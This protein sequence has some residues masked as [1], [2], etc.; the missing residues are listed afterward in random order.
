MS[1]SLPDRL[2][3]ELSH[4][5]AVHTGLSFP[6]KKW[7]ALTKGLGA[8]S[9]EAGFNDPQACARKILESE[10]SSS[11]LESLVEQLTIGE[12][13]FL[14][15]KQVF[16]ALQDHV[17]RGLV[18]NPRRPDKSMRFWSAGCATGE[19]PFSIAILMDRQ[20]HLDKGRDIRIAGTDVNQR[21][22]NHAK[23]GIYTAWSLRGVPVSIIDKYF[24][25]HPPNRFELIPRIRGKV[26][27]SRLNFAVPDYPK[28]LEIPLPVDVILCRNVLM[29][30]DAISRARILERLVELLETNGW[31]ITSPAE[32]GFVSS[33]VLTPVRFS[34]AVFFRKGPAR[35]SDAPPK[36]LN[37]SNLSVHSPTGHKE[38]S[39]SGSPVHNRNRRI[40]D[41]HKLSAISF[42]ETYEAA[43]SDYHKGRYR[44]AA[45]KLENILV[46]SHHRNGSF[47]MRSASMMLLA[48][49]RANLGELKEAESACQ[50]AIASEKLNPELYYLLSTIHQAGNE[51]EAAIRSLKQTLYLDPDFV[52]AQF[53]LGLLMRQKGRLEE[54]YKRFSTT[55]MLLKTKPAGEIL[56]YS[57]GMTA[58]RLLET[59]QSLMS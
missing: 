32:A 43:N 55:A 34:N 28:H 2:L 13:Y 41:T 53:Q 19:E 12:T 39:P 40:T 22:L 27:F 47:L 14:R 56:P 6:E 29:Y 35:K 7:Q 52:M 5:L 46:S 31:L 15:D 4:H 33:G 10:P 54:S 17:I 8:V 51:I 49:C 30:H 21:F 57:E 48:R 1:A 45:E 9:R 36:A 25:A 42:Q 37:N 3:R 20:F 16:Q 24:I 18:E 26:R 50:Q 23:A 38:T 59:V 44:A 11:L 58:G